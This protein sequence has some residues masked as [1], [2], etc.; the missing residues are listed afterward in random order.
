MSAHGKSGVMKVQHGLLL[1][2]LLLFVLLLPA[3]Q[4]EEQVQR[5]SYASLTESVYASA[6][7][8]PDS[9]YAVYAAVGGII[10]EVLVEEGQA[11]KLR[12]P[13]FQLVGRTPILNRENARLTYELSKTNF[14][15]KAAVLADLEQE[16]RTAQLQWRND[17]TDYARQQ[18]LWGKGIG[19]NRELESRELAYAVSG[20]KV[21]TL[22]NQLDRTQKELQTQVQQAANSL[23]SRAEQADNYVVSSRIHGKVYRLLK[24]TGESVSAQE[25]MAY[26]GS[27]EQFMLELQVDEVDIARVQLGQTVLVTLDAYAGEVFEA[28]VSQIVPSMDQQLQTFLVKAE[29][30]NPPAVLYAG[31][32]GEANIIISEKQRALTIPLELLAD[33]N[34]VMTSEGL[35]QV[36]TGLRTL[37]RIEI[38]SGLD[39]NTVLLKPE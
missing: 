29:F 2:G 32:G 33:A 6:T 22:Q 31:F 21:K 27:A 15:G 3:C 9:L 34:S 20:N 8:Q 25:P 36:E 17:S 5:A 23:A 13:L 37:D 30:E 18:T 14:E 19:T 10:E 4:T 38:L 35:R 7:V 26:V 12:D 28:R 1:Q 39:T 16:L 24:K 11:V